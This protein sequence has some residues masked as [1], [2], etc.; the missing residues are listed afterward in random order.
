M[1]GKLVTGTFKCLGCNSKWSY[2][3]GVGEYS[4]HKCP[5]CGYVYLEWLDFG[6]KD[7]RS[8]GTGGRTPQTSHETSSRVRR[9]A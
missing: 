7:E 9:P 2:T 5:V 4:A 6:G 3:W 1:S 8:E